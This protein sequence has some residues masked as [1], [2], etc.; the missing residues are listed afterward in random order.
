MGKV[1]CAFGV[2]CVLWEEGYLC[3]VR[4]RLPVFGWEKFACVWLEEDGGNV[5]LCLVGK[6][7]TCV[8]IASG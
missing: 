6:R 2:T 4:K 3:V 5:Y 7:V 8:W 1:T